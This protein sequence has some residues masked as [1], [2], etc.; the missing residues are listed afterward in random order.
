MQLCLC[1]Q[2]YRVLDCMLAK[3]LN[4]CMFCVKA[5]VLY[6]CVWAGVVLYAAAEPWQGVVGPAQCSNDTLDCV[7][8]VRHALTLVES[9]LAPPQRYSRLRHVITFAQ[10]SIFQ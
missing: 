8:S 10:Y 4:A 9:G 7:E 5:M 2:W 1:G 3:T 6:G